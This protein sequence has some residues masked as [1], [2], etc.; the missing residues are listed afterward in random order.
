[1]TLIYKFSL[2]RRLLLVI[3]QSGGQIFF[4]QSLN[5]LMELLD[6]PTANLWPKQLNDP[7]IRSRAYDII[8]HIKLISSYIVKLNTAIFFL[9]SPFYSLLN[10]LLRINHVLIH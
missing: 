2:Q 1:M 8:P 9:G 10:R 3:L 6:T 4:E 5:N 7:R